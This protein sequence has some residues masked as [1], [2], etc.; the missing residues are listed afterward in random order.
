MGTVVDAAW[1][2]V[3]MV[4]LVAAAS[5]LAAVVASSLGAALG[6]ALGVALVAALGVA[7][8]RTSSGDA[9]EVHKS[10]VEQTHLVLAPPSSSSFQA[11]AQKQQEV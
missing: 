3:Q 5:S 1:K 10:V 9:V 8:A 6:V 2:Y 7:L 4:H 11:A